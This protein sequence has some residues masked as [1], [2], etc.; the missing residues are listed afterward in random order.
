MSG[1]E[2]ATERQNPHLRWAAELASDLLSRFFYLVPLAPSYFPHA[3]CLGGD[4]LNPPEL[5]RTIGGAE[6]APLVYLAFPMLTLAATCPPLERPR[7]LP[8]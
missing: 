4:D 2:I 6:G 1:V 8:H 7:R 3:S 5:K